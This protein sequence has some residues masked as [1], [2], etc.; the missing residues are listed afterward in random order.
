MKQNLS[1]ESGISFLTLQNLTEGIL[2]EAA[3]E[4]KELIPDLFHFVSGFAGGSTDF[5]DMEGGISPLYAGV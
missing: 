2:L 5:V 4:E 3:D 1:D